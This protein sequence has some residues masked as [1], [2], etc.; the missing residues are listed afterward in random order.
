VSYQRQINTVA[1]RGA[2]AQMGDGT[3]RCVLLTT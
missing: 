3:S 2:F 1:A